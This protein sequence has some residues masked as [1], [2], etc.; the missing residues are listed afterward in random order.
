MSSWDDWDDDE[1][2]PSRRRYSDDVRYDAPPQSGAVT[3]A[4]VVSI[5]MAV[6]SMLCGGCSGLSGLF[7]TAV[8][9]GAR[10]Q[11]NIFPPDMFDSAAGV[12]LGWALLHLVLGVGLLIGG[13][14][15]L[16]RRNWGRVL[17][18]MVAAVVALTGIVQF[19][20]F[21]MIG[22]GDF[23]GLFGA[24]PEARVGQSIMGCLGA[25]LYFAYAIFV[26]IILLSSHNKAEFD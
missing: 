10:Q 22:I 12:L 23:G 16:Q 25:L 3:G 19:G 17:T 11:G 21:L 13:I 26:Y 24:D 18:L 2:R 7:C 5:G 8:G 6:L 4:G 20:F 9:A 1:P 15:T 14:V